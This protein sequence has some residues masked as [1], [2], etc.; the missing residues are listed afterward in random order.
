VLAGDQPVEQ[1][2]PLWN[3]ASVAI[4]AAAIVIGLLVL[5]GSKGGGGDYASA[6]GGGV[7]FIFGIAGACVI[8]EIAA[9]VALVRG[10]RMAWLTILGILGNGVVIVPV[11]LLLL[12]D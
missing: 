4:P 8:G 1:V 6:L 11:L 3:I 12:K 9:W 7:L 5:A 2:A 10:E